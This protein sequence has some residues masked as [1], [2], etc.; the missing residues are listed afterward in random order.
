MAGRSRLVGY[1]TAAL[2]VVAGVIAALVV[3]GGTGQVLAFILIAVGLILATS[4]VFLEVGLSE[5]R[6]LEREARARAARAE[7]AQSPRTRRLRIRPLGRE[8]DHGRRLR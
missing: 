2:L 7:A 8:R 5:D 1:G 4:L 6:Q 3:G